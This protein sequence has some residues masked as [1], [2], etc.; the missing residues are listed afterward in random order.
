MIRKTAHAGTFYPRFSNQIAE[1]V[2]KWAADAPMPIVTERAIG[3]ILPHAGYMYSGKCATLGLASIAHE[4]FDSIIILHPSHQANHFD[5]SLSPYTEYETPLGNLALD[6][7][8]YRILSPHAFQNLG[9]DYHSLEHSMEIMLPL[10]RYFFP[11]TRICPVM[12]GN[13]IPAV[14]TR[15]ADLLYDVVYKSSRRILILV[16]SD[17]SHY[18]PASKAEEM[19]KLLTKDVLALDADALWKDSIHGNL[20][21]CG[22]GGIMALLKLSKKY[23]A[24]QARVIQYTH[25]GRTSGNNNQVVGYLAAKIF[26]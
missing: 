23:T 14:A 24:P 22:I 25:S 19:D 4:V 2:Q 11:E 12:I 20:E 5:F 26:I 1:Q 10:L 9:M 21:A 18:H 17:L 7:E 6:G 15:L 16:S 8:L 13:Q 3:L